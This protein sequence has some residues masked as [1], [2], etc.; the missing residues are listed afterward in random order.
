ME[1][2]RKPLRIASLLFLCT[3][4]ACV[5]INIYFPAEKVET[6]AQD[7]VDDIR[8]REG[9]ED[10]PSDAEGKTSVFQ[11][12]RTCLSPGI[13]QAQDVTE[14]SNATIRAL[15]ERMKGRYQQMKPFYNSGLIK[16]G[17]DGYVSTGD[18]GSLGLK[19]KRDLNGL[20]D[21]ENK[22]RKALYQEVAKALDIDP[23]Q[24]DRIAK[25][26]AKEWQK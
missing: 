5:T 11:L 24:I 21:A 25:I 7:I 23:G 3:L 18:L 6:V 1:G 4:L 22:D 17:D 12:I 14:V 26:F 13:A 19:E 20:V 8:G 9:T 16:E 2:I 10:T 15:K